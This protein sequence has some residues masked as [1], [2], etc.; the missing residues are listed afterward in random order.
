MR[1]VEI[2]SIGFVVVRVKMVWSFANTTDA[3]EMTSLFSRA[4]KIIDDNF[5]FNNRL[6]VQGRVGGKKVRLRVL[7]SPRFLC[8]TFPTKNATK[9]LKSIDFPPLNP[10]NKQQYDARITTLVA[11]HRTHAEVVVSG[12]G[13]T[14]GVTPG[15][16]P[17]NALV[18]QDGTILLIFTNSRF[19][20][21]VHRVFA[22]LVG[23]N[24][25]RAKGPNDFQALFQSLAPG[26]VVDRVEQLG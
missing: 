4:H 9:F 14:P 16:S 25:E 8:R 17:R 2:R 1:Q 3:D 22:Q 26:L 24:D 12:G 10:I 21:D 6:A 18:R 13:G 11:T 7:F 23:L 15:G 19:D 20:D 5:N